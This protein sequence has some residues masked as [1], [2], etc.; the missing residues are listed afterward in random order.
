MLKNVACELKKQKLMKVFRDQMWLL[1]RMKTN[2]SYPVRF[3]TKYSLTLIC[4]DDSANIFN[5]FERVI[6]SVCC[7]ECLGDQ[8]SLP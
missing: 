4:R 8:Y 2:V 7:R 5:E 6:K 1:G 3:K